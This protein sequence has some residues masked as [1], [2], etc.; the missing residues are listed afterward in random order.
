MIE[1]V[2]DDLDGGAAAET[3]MFG[4]DGKSYEID[5]G[6]RNAAA[7]RKAFKPYVAAA[8]PSSGAAV[9]RRGAAPPA[10]R[11]ARKRATAP[12]RDY[13]LVALR[14]WAGAS[15]VSVPSRGRIPQAVVE[16]SKASGGS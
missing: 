9:S 4:L 13:D 8:R 3:I 12:K 2:T 10:K 15:D 7:M 5:L 11:S 1:R 16:Q 14:E 6:K